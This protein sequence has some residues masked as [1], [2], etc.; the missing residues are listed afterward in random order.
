[1]DGGGDCSDEGG[2]I[3]GVGGGEADV[4]ALDVG[5]DAGVAELLEEVAEIRHREFV[6]AADVDAAEQC[7]VGSRHRLIRAW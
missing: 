1:M 2:L 5:G 4:A 7:D 3:G 6:V